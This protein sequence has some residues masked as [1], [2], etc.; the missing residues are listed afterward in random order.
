MPS[1][2][3]SRK[4]Q[5]RKEIYLTPNEETQIK[6]TMSEMGVKTFQ[7]Y[8]KNMLVQGQVV[9]IDF[10][11]LKDLRVA[12][13]RI[14]GN[15]NQIAKHANE[16]DLITIEEISEVVNLLSEIKDLVNAKVSSEEKRSIAQ[17]KQIVR[18]YDEW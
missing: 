17:K 10:S 11:E 18:T 12:I 4:R 16:N 7:S 9:Q 15:I 5:I 1:N 14:G 13:N 8:A 2:M 6:R 3:K